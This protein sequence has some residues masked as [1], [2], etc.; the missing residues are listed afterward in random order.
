[1]NIHA[2]QPAGSSK[3]TSPIPAWKRMLDIACLTF[4]F[5]VWIT[6]G[7]CVG[8]LVKLT[9]RGPILFKQSRIG[10]LGRP[11]LCLKF[12]TMK[13]DA[14][15][16]I[17]QNHLA[18]L[19]SSGS[20]M[21]KLDSAGDPRLTPCGLLLRSLGL[22]ELPQL[23]NVLRREMSLVGPRP[24]LPYE[25]ET[26]LPRHRRRFETAPGL[27]GLW[28]T[29][30]KNKTT[31]EEMI[32]L[33]VHYAVHKT[34]WLDLKIMLRTI[35][36]ILEQAGEVRRSRKSSGSVS[37]GESVRRRLGRKSEARVSEASR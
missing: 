2:D 31:F 30:G 36:A 15:T 26:Y 12:R 10:Y 3:E 6:V 29:S 37:E 32:D 4:T 16:A 22:D 23:I 28:Q 14:D 5:P 25:Y 11:F 21:T 13:T 20:P 33:D 34:F 17:H 19:M 27:T 18:E 7:L 24:C 35:P 9:S 8:L 1:M